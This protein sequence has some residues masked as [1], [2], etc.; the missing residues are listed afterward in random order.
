[1]DVYARAFFAANV[2]AVVLALVSRDWRLQIIAIGLALVQN[3]GWL[4]N[5]ES[6]RLLDDTMSAVVM[7]SL[8]MITQRTVQ[9]EHEIG[10][11]RPWWLVPIALSQ[12]AIL[13][14]SL[15]GRSL[16]DLTLWRAYNGL[17]AIALGVIIFTACRRSVFPTHQFKQF[18]SR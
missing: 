4:L 9:F 8:V 15:F 13:G 18:R 1:M 7:I 10:M 14:L 6:I 16:S 5:A 12:L 3:I 2:V 11:H 17:Y